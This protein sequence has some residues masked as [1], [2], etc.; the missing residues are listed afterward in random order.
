M[1][2][3]LILLISSMLSVWA[4]AQADS[5]AL[6]NVRGMVYDNQS[7]DPLEGAQVR[8]LRD[9]L[10]VAGAVVGKNGQFVLPGVRSGTYTLQVSFIGYKE[11]RFALTL[12]KRAGNFR[13]KDVLLREDAKVM[14]EAVVEGKLP[15]MTV[16]SLLRVSVGTG[17]T[18][19]CVS[20][21]LSQP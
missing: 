5:V 17:T 4:W 9:T 6:V 18:M 1:R 13:V 19:K 8:L 11:Q 12:P 14:A 2:R 7:F 10:Q 20:V 21:V 3:F 15:E 16:V